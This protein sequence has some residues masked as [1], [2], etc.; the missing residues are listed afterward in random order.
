MSFGEYSFGDVSFAAS[1]EV[2][3]LVE[4]EIDVD[5][6]WNITGGIQKD[7]V[8]RHT[9]V[10]GLEK[11][12]SISWE[13]TGGVTVDFVIDHTIMVGVTKDLVLQ[14]TVVGGITKDVVVD[15]EIANAVEVTTELQWYVQGRTDA[16]VGNNKLCS[17]KESRKLKICG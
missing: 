2:G 6:S 3:T 11:D 12:F 5:I 7:L 14:H 4:L 1:E 15:Y 9:I 8:L 16:I 13:I 17:G 10:N